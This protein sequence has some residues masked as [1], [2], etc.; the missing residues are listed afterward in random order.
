MKYFGL[1]INLKDDSEIVERYR[2]YHQNVWPE[3]ERA[4][5]RTGITQMKIFLLG[6]RLF[7]YM[8]TD[9]SYDALQAQRVYL[10]QTRVPE[11][12]ALMQSLQEPV[13]EA[14]SGESWALMELVYELKC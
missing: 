3:I 8:E 14:G 7:M 10:E 6:R 9:D 11:W 13:P 2:N 1:T 4:L 5:R 12:E